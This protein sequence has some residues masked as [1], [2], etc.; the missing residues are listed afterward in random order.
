[1]GESSKS[2]SSSLSLPSLPS[3]DLSYPFFR[4]SGPLLAHRKTLL[5]FHRPSDLRSKR[6]HQH[7]LQLQPPRR[8]DQ[9]KR[10]R[11]RS[12]PYDSHDR[13]RKRNQRRCWRGRRKIR[14]LTRSF[15][16]VLVA[17]EEESFRKV[18]FCL[19]ALVRVFLSFSFLRIP[20]FF[21]SILGLL[22]S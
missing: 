21:S 14:A 13:E 11:L 12:L 5:H 9:R 2:S 17:E 6:Q 16:L 3:T 15:S 1:M 8:L 20:S 22:L 7:V 19:L 4:L 18:V 10:N